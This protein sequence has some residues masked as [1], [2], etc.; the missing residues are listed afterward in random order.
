MPQPYPRAVVVAIAAT[1]AVP[2][3]R[4]RL[5]H[6]APGRLAERGAAV[7]AHAAVENG[8]AKDVCAIAEHH[9][10]VQAEVVIGV[11]SLREQT[12]DNTGRSW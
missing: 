2:H 7:R 4:D 11:V 1:A 3:H 6:P 9:G 10:L 12:V 5:E 8:V